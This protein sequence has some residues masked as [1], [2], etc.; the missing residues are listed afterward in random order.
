MKWKS[1]TSDF[2]TA[3]IKAFNETF[4]NIYKDI[5]HYGCYFHY[6]KNCRKKLIT[7]GFGANDIKED[8]KESISFS[9]ELPF[10][11][12]ISQNFTSVINIV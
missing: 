12:N 9:S 8:Y 5:Q 3:L 1:Y 11:K 2:E 4:V 10:K 6:L 7:K